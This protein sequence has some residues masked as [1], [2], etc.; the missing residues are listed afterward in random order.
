MV[1][2]SNVKHVYAQEGTSKLMESTSRRL[3]CM[4][5]LLRQ[6]KDDF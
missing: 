4:L 6:Q 5:Q 3:I 2:S 1:N